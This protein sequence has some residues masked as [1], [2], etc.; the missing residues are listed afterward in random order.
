MAVFFEVLALLGGEGEV[1]VSG[2]DDE[3]DFEK[4]LVGELDGFEAP[5]GGDGGFLLDGSEEFIAEALGG[6]SAGV[7]EVSAFDGAFF[8]MG[9]EGE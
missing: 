8:G 2:H 1:I 5:L 7:D 4:F 6:V 3:G 9:E